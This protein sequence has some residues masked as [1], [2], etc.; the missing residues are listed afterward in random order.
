M[1]IFTR[2]LTWQIEFDLEQ[3][4]LVER[5][6]GLAFPFDPRFGHRQ[7]PPFHNLSQHIYG[8]QPGCDLPF[9]TNVEL[10]NMRDPKIKYTWNYN[11]EYSDQN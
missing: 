4:S 7:K 10:L 8:N 6:E 11:H 1:V 3:D 9:D 2:P 5:S